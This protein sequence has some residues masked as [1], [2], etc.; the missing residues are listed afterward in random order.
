MEQVR[1]FYEQVVGLRVGPRPN[2]TSFGYWL[3]AGEVDILHLTQ[4]KQG[5]ERR[6]GQDLTFDHV[7]LDCTDW[8]KHQQILDKHSVKYA[9]GYVPQTDKH[10]VFFRDP[11]GNGVELLF[12]AK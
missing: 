11:A 8:P 9:E 6:T 10:Q 12:A 3:Y 5:D 2:F 4:E 7:A 1:E